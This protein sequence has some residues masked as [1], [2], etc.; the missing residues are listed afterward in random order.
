[1]MTRNDPPHRRRARGLHCKYERFVFWI[2]L[3]KTVVVNLGSPPQNDSTDCG[4]TLV[5]GKSCVTICKYE[6]D[7]GTTD[8]HHR[9]SFHLLAELMEENINKYKSVNYLWCVVWCVPMM[10]DIVV[11]VVCYSWPECSDIDLALV[12]LTIITICMLN[13]ITLC[14]FMSDLVCK[15]DILYIHCCYPNL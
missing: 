7:H 8:S 12:S 2:L 11:Y 14:S 3:G 9:N 10:T 5:A 6:V 1:M 4:G 13:N 15:L